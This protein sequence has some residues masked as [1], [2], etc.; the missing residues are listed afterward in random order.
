[1]SYMLRR[2]YDGLLFKPDAQH[3]H[4]VVGLTIL[5][6]QFI[7]FIPNINSILGLLLIFVILESLLF[8]NIRGALSILW[9]LFPVIIVL[10]GFTF[11]FGG[12]EVL[13]RILSR[14]LIGAVGF[15]FFFTSTN[16]SDFTRVLERIKI[17]SKISL[18]PALT[19]MMIPRIAKDAEDT[20]NTLRL[21]GE[22]KGFIFNWLPK[23]L[24]I[25]VA[26]VIYRSEFLAQSL[27]FK[28]FGILKRT[29]YRTVDFN[30]TDILRILFWLCFFVFIIIL[31]EFGLLAYFG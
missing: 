23:T 26:S 13:F 22:I 25:Y 14:F 1:M 28:G 31:N 18:I 2:I 10:G 11:L 6:L 3:I 16:P 20:F 15:S 9:A 17:N 5:I 7:Y 8:N 24:A 4:P 27:Y 29:H 19:L 21:R 30:K 12:W